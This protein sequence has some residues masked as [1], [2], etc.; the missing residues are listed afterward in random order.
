[1]PVPEAH[2]KRS[3]MNVSLTPELKRF[4]EEKVDGGLYTSASEVIREGLRLLAE[5]DKLREIRR[6]EFGEKVRAGLEELKRGEGVDGD[7]V[8][9]KLE[10]ELDEQEKRAGKT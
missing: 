6:R 5:E 4:V 2:D 1:M 8:F 10:A 7:K 9:D 3:T